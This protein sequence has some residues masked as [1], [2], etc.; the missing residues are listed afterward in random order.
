MFDWLINWEEC[1]SRYYNVCLNLFFK[2]IN[3]KYL[4]VK[5]YKMEEVLLWIY[6]ENNN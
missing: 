3:I 2:A 6:N 1:I 4:I 5:D